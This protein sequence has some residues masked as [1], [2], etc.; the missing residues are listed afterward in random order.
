MILKPTFQEQSM[1]THPSAQILY[2]VE[3]KH[4]SNPKTKN[5]VIS[6]WKLTL[7]CKE[8]PFRSQ[9][10]VKD[11]GVVFWIRVKRP[12]IDF[13]HISLFP[14]CA[15]NVRAAIKENFNK[16]RSYKNL[17]T[18]TKYKRTSALYYWWWPRREE[19]QKWLNK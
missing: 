17:Y 19:K 2:D 6:M 3:Y 5:D 16:K 1:L 4:M 7:W 9:I 15:Q 10:Y 14:R 11:E 13:S 18:T 12:F 8:F